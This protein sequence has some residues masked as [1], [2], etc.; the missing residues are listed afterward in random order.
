[1]VTQFGTII[2]PSND[3][4]GFTYEG[5]TGS[6]YVGSNGSCNLSTPVW[7]PEKKSLTYKAAAPRFAT[8]G[9]TVNSGFYYATISAADA[10]ALWGL[11]KAEDATSALVVS[12]KT[13]AGGT[14]GATKTVAVK[15]GKVIIQVFGF[16]FPDPML[17]ISLNPSY[18][19]LSTSAKPA[20][21]MSA[22]ATVKKTAT[23]KPV[24]TAKETTISCLKGN[25]LKKVTGV[26][27]TCPTGYKKK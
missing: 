23:P 1:V 17:D 5:G 15:N 7:S 27:P 14:T 18:D 4:M 22:Q 12:L 6:I 19:A 25:Q 3:P 26:K 13:T 21:N 11:K 24:A 8:D 10:M 20:T 2:V 9:T 16:E